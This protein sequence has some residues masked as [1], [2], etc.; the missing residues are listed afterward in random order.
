MSIIPKT[1]EELS[2]DKLYIVVRSDISPGLKCAQACHAMRAFQNTH[3]RV[4][5]EWYETSNNIA[6]LEAPY[7]E[8]LRLIR[9]ANSKEIPCELFNEEDMD[10]ALTAAAFAPKAKRLLSKCK[11]ALAS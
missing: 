4:E 5:R 1:A 6:I 3:P 10:G 7:E 11:L 9:M 8:L 2:M